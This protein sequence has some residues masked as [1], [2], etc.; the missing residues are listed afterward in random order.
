MLKY[1]SVAELVNGAEA[2]GLK[3][4]ELVLADQAEAMEASP[5][6][7]YEKTRCRT[8]IGLINLYYRGE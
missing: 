5:E 4:S 1:E 3:I 2:K 7:L 6:A 8:R